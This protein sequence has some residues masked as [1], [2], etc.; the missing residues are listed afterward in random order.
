MTAARPPPADD[1]VR[2]DESADREFYDQP[3]FVQHIDDAAIA[4]VTAVIRR[5]VAP[6]AD[7]LDLM[8]SWVSHL[9]PAT[10]L[11]LGRVAGLGMN[12]KELAANPRLT[13]WLVHDLNRGERLPF[14]DAA[15]AAVLITVSIQYLTR[16]VE[17]L[18]EVARVL[19]P[20]GVVLVSFSD[21]M[22][23]TKAV[24][25]WQETPAELRPR[26]VACYLELAGGFGEIDTEGPRRQRGL[27]GGPDPLW[28]VIGRRAEADP[29]P[30]PDPDSGLVPTR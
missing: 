12:A 8:S 19:R 11:P 30:D 20:G 14:G 27:F 24:R 18:C 21:R 1:F 9:P 4:G 10:E 23:P 26:L 22:F 3:R 25:V 7:L 29:D 2:I 28:V 5:H 13:E 16:P 17:T 15:F 6:G